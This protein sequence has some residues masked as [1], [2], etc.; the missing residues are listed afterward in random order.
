MMT[1]GISTASLF[2]RV[3]TEDAAA[4]LAEWDVG[5]V[6]VFLTSFSE[7]DRNFSKQ[8]A[9][10]LGAER[11]Y[12]V[13]VLGTQFEP[14]LFSEH[15]RVRADA[16][17]WLR[18]AMEAAKEIG[19]KHYSFHGPARMKRT[20]REDFARTG[21]C[22]CEVA[23]VC[24]EYGVALSLENVECAFYNRPGVFRRLQAFCPRLSGVLDLKQARLS[25]FSYAE[26]LEEMGPA[27]T[28]VHVSDVTE[29]GVM[30][31]PG[32]GTFDFDDLLLRLRDV[33]FGGALLIENYRK[34]YADFG[35]LK[36]SY[37]FLAE[38]VAKY[39]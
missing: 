35:A 3:N 31:L 15:P 6:E 13:H 19:A 24:A 39:N 26:Y 33:G 5:A 8:V 23:S 25:G 9:S 37:E 30:C 28:H 20:F 38:K 10:C 21:P 34:D 29:A 14:Q 16:Y 32:T 1:A 17:V 11:A 36:A 12:S 7:Y 4:L 18:R 22:L 2:L 27:L